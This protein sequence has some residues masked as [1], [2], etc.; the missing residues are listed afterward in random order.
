MEQS[1]YLAQV[2]H[3]VTEGTSKALT[4]RRQNYFLN[5]IAYNDDNLADNTSALF[6][7]VYEITKQALHSQDIQV[8]FNGFKFLDKAVQNL[9]KNLENNEDSV[10]KRVEQQH[11]H[12]TREM[13][14]EMANEICSSG[15]KNSALG[16]YA[17]HYQAKQG[18]GNK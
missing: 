8:A 12:S 10:S 14:S 18:L 17:R 2:A 5:K 13:L 9:E 6:N 4:D 15:Q 3:K 16:S 1:E 11:I 7:N